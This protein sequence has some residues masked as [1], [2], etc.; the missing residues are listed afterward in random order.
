MS[1]P[2]P[3]VS[4]TVFSG[5][6]E[7]SISREGRSTSSFIKSIRL[8][9]PAMNFADGSAAIMPYSVGDVVAPARIEN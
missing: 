9:P 8:V 6:R 5:S 1:R 7:M 4:S 3:R 2:P